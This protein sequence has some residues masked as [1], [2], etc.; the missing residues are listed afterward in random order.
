MVSVYFRFAFRSF[1]SFFSFIRLRILCCVCGLTAWILA[2][3]L[4]WSIVRMMLAAALQPASIFLHHKCANTTVSHRS[5]HVEGI[6]N[7]KFDWPKSISWKR[8][9]CTE[10]R[11]RNCFWNGRNCTRSVCHLFSS[12]SLHAQVENVR[13]QAL[14]IRL[15]CTH[16][17]HLNFIDLFSCQVW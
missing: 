1:F 3:K 12:I 14:R 5:L 17:V 8:N 10:A 13:R 16:T 15:W 2:F 11:T 7:G 4:R 6:P 9:S